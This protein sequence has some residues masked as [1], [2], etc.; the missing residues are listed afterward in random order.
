VEKLNRIVNELRN[1]QE[2]LSDQAPGDAQPETSRDD[3][4]P[5]DREGDN[6]PT[7]GQ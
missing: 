5:H 6:Q 4:P 7:Q 2:Q 1:G 3:S